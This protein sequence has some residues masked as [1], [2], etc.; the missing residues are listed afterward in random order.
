MSLQQKPDHIKPNIQPPYEGIPRTHWSIRL[1][2][3]ISRRNRRKRTQIKT[4]QV[5]WNYIASRKLIEPRRLSSF[6]FHSCHILIISNFRKYMCGHGRRTLMSWTMSTEG[7]ASEPPPKN[8]R[9]S[10]WGGPPGTGPQRC[11]G[12]GEVREDLRS[13][14]RAVFV[15]SAGD[16]D[17]GINTICIP[18]YL[19]TY[20]SN[21]LSIY[22]SIYLP[23]I[24][25]IHLSIG[26]STYLSIIY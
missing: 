13:P 5:L 23:I 2:L 24:V 3:K 10:S 1:S 6:I 7:L 26:L 16:S 4:L 11:G 25:Y 22:W 17:Q 21:I 8:P 9:R 14:E 20:H 18:A 19:S 15:L 12:G